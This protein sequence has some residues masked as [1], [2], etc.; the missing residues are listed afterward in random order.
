MELF[1]LFGTIAIQNADANDAI[2]DT[3]GR[4]EQSESK[5]SS[6]FKKIGTAVVTFFATDK[7]INF[8]KSCVE[9]AASVKAA[10]SQFEQ[11]FGNMASEANAAMKRVADS[12]GIMQTRLQE[13]GTSIFAF[14][15]TTGMD[16]AEA[17]QMMEEALN[18]TADSAAYYD[19]SLEDTAESLKSFLKGNF[20]NDAALG[21]SCTETTRNAAAN[22][23]Y[24]KSFIEL[25]E[26]Q[27]QL[28]LLQMVKD[29]NELSGAMGQAARESDGWENVTG[30]LK[31]SWRQFQAVIGTPILQQL[32]PIIQKIST[33]ISQL[34]ATLQSGSIDVDAFRKKITDLFSPQFIEAM[35]EWVDYLSDVILIFAD[36]TID[37]FASKLQGV[38]DLFKNFGT[39]V[40]PIVETTLLTITRRFDD[41]LVIWNDV[42]VPAISFVIDAFLDLSNAI[43]THIAPPIQKISEKVNELQRCI[44]AAIQNYIVPAIQAFIDMIQSLWEENQDKIELIGQLF[45]TVFERIASI[46]SWFVDAFKN[47]IYPLFAWLSQTVI[48]NM[49]KIKAVFQSIF[50]IIG[51]IVKFFIALFK[52]DWSGM[53]DAVKSILGAAVD[54]IQNLFK[55]MASLIG[56]VITA[57]K[58]K[59]N[60]IF[61]NIVSVIKEKV[62]QIAESVSEKFETIKETISTIIENIKTAV[63]EKFES[64]KETIINIFTA[65]K[66]TVSNIWETI[67][68][69]VQVAIMFIGE[70][71]NAAFQIITLPWRFIWEN[72]KEYILAAWEA[73]KS[74]VSAALDTISTAITDAW[75]AIVDFLTPILEG[76]KTTFTDIWNAIKDT[77]GTVVNTIKTAISTAWN[78]IKE[79]ISTVMG[80]I[81]TNVSSIW[82]SIK[83]TVSSVINTIK[84]IVSSVFNT[85]KTTVSN[86]LNGIKNTFSDIWNSIKSAVSN[87]VNDVKSTVSNGMNNAKNTVSGIL[88]GIKN[89]FSSIFEGAKNIV[90]GAI[91]KIK[92]FFNFSWSLPKL[93]MPHP[94]ISGSFSLNPP[95]VPHFSIDWYKKA[96]EEPYMFTKPTIFDVNPV[97]G[98]ARGAG[99]AGDEVMIGKD[100]MLNMIR[101]AVAAENTAL[102]EKFDLLIDLLGAFFPKVLRMLDTAIVLDDGTLVGRLA[103]KMDTELGKIMNHKGRGN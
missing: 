60:E 29:A 68:N 51:G 70:L 15:R 7:I 75:N 32:V 3:T 12:S 58:D 35:D 94:K 43:L 55:L 76:I 72:C 22:K 69:A 6:A 46:V 59:V 89:K 64:V 85:I 16:S 97:T 37:M 1:R 88:D 24:G 25:S 78:S 40:Q 87:S 27:K 20:E 67:K 33:G 101:Q 96:M 91:D 53:W 73:I 95:S 21:L 36:N 48:S 9:A 90:K 102:I 57:I 30:N 65:V 14:A 18:V 61:G 47:Y 34:T 66:D 13:T 41:L 83:D 4:A 23:L 56:S 10:N 63:S 103:P 26:S 84:S 86:I 98:H 5:I 80:V 52:G 44:S 54:Y 49:D 39:V 19:R 93:K 50:D 8:G 2:D 38:S 28:T 45:Q 11:T 71:L 92:G 42:L 81:Q 62:Q 82:N 74:A 99:E 100:T 17:L 79:M 77:I 31:E